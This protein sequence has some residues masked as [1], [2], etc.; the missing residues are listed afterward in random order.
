MG[1]TVNIGNMDKRVNSTAC[2]GF[3][4]SVTAGNCRLKEGCDIRN[5]VIIVQGSAGNYNY[6]EW[7]GRYYWV[8]SIIP[9]P[10]SIIEVHA[11]LDPLATYKD[12]IKQAYAFISYSHNIISPEVLDL[13]MQPEIVRPKY[14]SDIDSIFDS[15]STYLSDGSVIITCFEAGLGTGNQGVKTYAVSIATFLSMLKN[16]QSSLY[17]A[18]YNIGSN[19]TDINNNLAN[20]TGPDD[21]ANMIGAIGSVALH[22]IIKALSD[23]ISNIGGFGSWRDNLIK[24][25]Y[26]PIKT[27]SIPTSGSKNIHL[28]FLDTGT[29]GNLV[30]PVEVKTK[31]SDIVIPWDTNVTQYH[32]L[33]YNKYSQLQAV[34]GGGQ[35]TNI[36]TDIVRDLAPGDTLSVHTAIDVCSG[37]WA[38]TLN[39]DT[40]VNSMRLA[41]FGG[42][43]GIDIV[44]M[45]SKG[46]LGMGMNYTMAGFKMAT[47]AISMG[48]SNGIGAGAGESAASIG[49]GIASQFI[50]NNCGH[51][52]TG[53]SGNGISSIFL[54]GSTGF[55]DFTLIGQ[56]TIPTMIATAGQ[57]DTYC[58]E[59]GYPCNQY[60]MLSDSWGGFCKCEGASVTTKGNQQEQAY[61][62]SVLNSGI[63]L[64]D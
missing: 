15:T 43:I 34:C 44:G 42:N 17:D 59:Y 27:S 54:N 62:N 63:F 29:S 25:V 26:V 55:N 61:I 39:K 4:P 36:D 60:R 64:E 6:M 48:L 30:N 5:P 37:D 7:N 21:V 38:C 12:D 22:D 58:Q 1:F 52:P 16:L 14:V 9:F 11:H 13:R 46:G 41:S 10:N 53:V 28:G 50:Q 31:T 20:F 33:K 19:N 2:A 35:Y 56:C 45:A 18:Q 3:S 24:A 40:A 49:T 51:A 23:L 8:D 47:S 57:Y 32:W